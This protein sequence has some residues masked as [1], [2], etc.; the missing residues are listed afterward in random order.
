MH[1][2][3]AVPPKIVKCT[4]VTLAGST[5]PLM[6]SVKVTKPSSSDTDIAIEFAWKP[7][8]TATNIYYLYFITITSSNDIQPSTVISD[9]LA[10]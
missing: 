6:S 2:L 9:Q 5:G 10:I 1:A 4:I 7:T 3:L 8:A